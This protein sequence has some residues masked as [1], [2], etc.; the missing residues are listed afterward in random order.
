MFE[1]SSRVTKLATLSNFCN[2]PV[3]PCTEIVSSPVNESA[4]IVVLVVAVSTSVN[5][6]TPVIV[7]AEEAFVVPVDVMLRVS[8]P[9]S[10]V[11][12]SAGVIVAP[13]PNVAVMV[14]PPAVPVTLS[15]D[16][17][18]VND[19]PVTWVSPAATALDTAA[20]TPATAEVAVSASVTVAS[21]DRAE[22]AEALPLNP[23]MLSVD[24]ATSVV[25]AAAAVSIGVRRQVK[26]LWAYG[27][28]PKPMIT[29][30]TSP[31]V[32][33]SRKRYFFAILKT[34]F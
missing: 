21:H 2:E 30:F 5:F 3:D 11:M 26:C 4:S 6:S 27:F 14:S 20:E 13:V 9:A 16:V 12:V 10:P 18:R 23:I 28:G 22:A 33:S 34:D 1:I 31:E 29:R 25:N 17:L 24:D 15:A 32:H 19:E 7:T 8:V